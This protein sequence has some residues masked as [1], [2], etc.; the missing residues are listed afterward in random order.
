MKVQQ[1]W[2]KRTK[3]AQEALTRARR[4]SRAAAALLKKVAHAHRPA[5]KQLEKKLRSLESMLEAE[6]LKVPEYSGF[7][8]FLEEMARAMANEQDALAELEAPLRRLR[9]A[10]EGRS[11]KAVAMPREQLV[12]ARKGKRKRALA[13]DARD[14]ML[15]KRQGELIRELDGSSKD[16]PIEVRRAVNELFSNIVDAPHTWKPEVIAIQIQR[17][18]LH[19]WTKQ[20]LELQKVVA[21]RNMIRLERLK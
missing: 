21:E 18:G 15:Y 20:F 8:N 5:A 10:V 19:R 4:T 14:Q 1:L 2:L 3:E 9:K 6:R 13:T 12:K 7:R 16:D 17:H 11:A